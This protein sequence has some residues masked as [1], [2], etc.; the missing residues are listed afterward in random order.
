[1]HDKAFELLV[2]DWDGTLMDSI[3]SI[4]GCMQRAADDLAVG[5][6]SEARVRRTIGLGLRES[7]G[8]LGFDAQPDLWDRLVERYRHHWLSD[9]RHQVVL[10]PHVPA[11]LETLARRGHRLAIATG[12]SRRGL[13]RDLDMTG[14]AG[15]FDASRT[16]DETLSKP[17]PQMLLEILDELGVAAGAALVI[18]DTT[19]D[20]EMAAAAGVASVGVTCGSHAPDELVAARPLACLASVAELPAWLEARAGGSP[21]S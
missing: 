15:L 10:F 16:A 4:V 17:H 5:P 7:M 20:L 18:G 11:I 6:V 3:A 1:M 8:A 14:I 13:A 21:K 9:F 12:K 2:F 19:F